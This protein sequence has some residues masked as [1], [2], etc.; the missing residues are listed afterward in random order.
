MSLFVCWAVFPLVLALLCLGCGLIVRPSADVLTLPAGFALVIVVA[1]LATTNKVTAQAAPW[2]VVALAAAG[3]GL[4][5]PRRPDWWAARTAVAVFAAFAAPIVL[6][7]SAT[8]A[9]YIT[10]D[11]T[12]TFLGLTDRVMTYGRDIGGLD[13]STYQRVLDVN[14]AHGYPVGSFMPMGIGHAIVRQDVA[15]LFQPTIVFSAAMLALALYALAAPLVRSPRVRAV[16]VFVAAQPALLY[17]YSLWTGI[18]E[19]AAAAL[20]ALAA[21]LVAKRSLFALAVV[22]AALLDVVGAAGVVW[23]AP[24]VVLT[25]LARRRALAPLA[26]G[27]V[28]A[29][30]AWLTAGEF[31]RGVNRGPFTSETELGNLGRPLR[32]VQ[33]FGIWPSGDF[34]L[35]PDQRVL[36]YVLIA[37][38]IAAVAAGL[39]FAR[40]RGAL[41]YAA[42]AVVGVAV[43][44]GAGSPWI[45]AKTYAIATPAAALLAAIAVA[46]LWQRSRPAGA[47]VA[48]LLGG[49]VIWSNLLAYRDVWLAPRGQLAELER[50]GT[51]FAGGGPALMT[52][53][54][55]Y[56][57]RHF[58]RGLDAEG[59]SELRYRQVFLSDGTTL[60]K[61]AYADLDRFALSTILDYRTLVLRRSPSESRPPSVYRL[62]WRGAYYEVW[63]RRP[64]R[65]GSHLP[66]GDVLQPGAVPH[67]AAL[68]RGRLLAVPRARVAVAG[69]DEL[70]YP[71]RAETFSADVR[72]PAATTYTVWVGGSWR[73]Q[74][75]VAIDGRTV[76]RAR[77]V[78]NNTGQ[79]WRLGSVAVAPGIHR[80]TLHYRGADTHPASGGYALPLG[81]VV[82]APE[83]TPRVLEATAP[84]LCGRRLDW[85]ETT[86][87]AR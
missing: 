20:I 61:G 32:L 64:G 83:E 87:E 78:L 74:L 59:A 82:L 41:V 36:A 21:A 86:A 50:I 71:T 12:S 11:D 57:V 60:P 45:A 54:Q 28:L 84:A 51:R 39:A 6:S 37:L 56:G 63:Q 73:S 9:G 62:V 52:E 46:R 66:L 1:S 34:R 22:C 30:P 26:V 16:A 35:H 77:H 29:L 33:V 25:L 43:F 48:I 4:R 49:G 15:W 72:V 47:V 44:A 75:T 69:F 27:V 81:P 58:L 67:C 65:I 42:S 14:L 70:L 38:A 18:K 53:Y 3:L 68:P 40:S 10:L 79:Y 2:L 55:P 80:V 7:G 8:F 31:L 76:G 17:A 19:L 13:P 5:R 24:A 23:L 85:V